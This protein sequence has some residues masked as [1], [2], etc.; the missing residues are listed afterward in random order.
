M[1]DFSLDPSDA[2]DA[3][4]ETEKEKLVLFVSYQLLQIN[5]ILSK[6]FSFD[7]DNPSTIK[8]TPIRYYR[9]WAA[10]LARRILDIYFNTQ[11]RPYYTL[12][13]VVVLLVPDDNVEATTGLFVF[14]SAH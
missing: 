14:H 5:G 3:I 10:A 4:R 8:K 12:D 9:G 1:T 2:S 7:D 11:R 6:A 13:D